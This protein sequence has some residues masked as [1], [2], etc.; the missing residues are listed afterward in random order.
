MSKAIGID[1]GTTNSAAAFKALDTRIITNAEGEDL[2]PSVVSLQRKKKLIGQKVEFLIGRHALD[3]LQ[4]DPTNTITSIKRLMGRG[5]HD[6]DVQRMLG[7]GLYSYRI[8]PLTSGSEQSVAV[9]L[10]GKEYTPEQISAKILEKICKDCKKGLGDDVEYAVVT[11]PAYFNDKQKHSTRVAAA[12]AG[13]KVQRLLSEPTAAA[14]SFGVEELKANE[15]QTILVFDMGG[16]TFDLAVLTIAN[17]QFIEQGKGGDMWMGGDDI[18]NL[19]RQDVY[20]ETAIEHEIEDLQALIDALPDV[21]RSRFLGDIKSKVEIAKIRLGTQPKAVVEVLGLLRD[22]DGDILDIEVEI[23]RERFDSLLQPFVDR[24]MELTRN[25]LDSI[26]V[27]PERIDRVVM[28]GGSSSIPLIVRTMREFF[29]SDKVLLHDR[30]MLAIAEG[31]A[32]LAHRLADSYECPV[33]GKQVAQTD[34]TCPHCGFD[35]KADLVDKGVLDIVYTTSHD[36]YLA[37]ENGDDYQLVEKNTPLPF[38]TQYEFKLLDPEQRLIHFRFYNIVNGK[39]ESIGD[40][41]LGFKIEDDDEEQQ[42]R[43]SLPKVL[44]DLDLDN[45]NLLTVSARIKDK[46]DIRVSRTLSRGKADE[47]L[48]FDLRKSIDQANQ[49]NY[50][51]YAIYDFLDRVVF[52]TDMI[53]RIID[54]KTNEED[55]ALGKQIEA[56]QQTAFQLLEA[57]E[58]PLANLYYAEYFLFQV[59]EFIS[60]KDRKDLEAVMEEFRQR[61]ETGTPQQIMD[62]REKLFAALDKHVGL[63]TLVTLQ[64]AAEI[65]HERDPA[66]SPYFEKYIIDIG[67]ALRQGDSPNARQLLD[68]VMPEAQKE[69]DWK[70]NQKLRISHGIQQ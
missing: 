69:L 35:L 14:I 41:W 3:F 62:A 64:N 58:A 42:D 15:E 31:A 63:Q 60:D 4:R 22:K 12:L 33:C 24:A 32:I 52:I 21:E 61:N 39:Q 34:A 66:R 57:G 9:V 16:G 67:N 65:C 23:S 17:G 55:H 29:G 7:E 48:F 8:A 18:D 46:P 45:N 70:E 40:L 25:I 1:L 36:Y 54:P 43:G 50:K 47:K 56:C 44:L 53:N 38:H 19:L 68:E 5:F 6:Q 11:V 30:P 20:R 2:T 49:G 59:G 26:S 51:Y 13:I 10:D 27:E 37:L 28:V